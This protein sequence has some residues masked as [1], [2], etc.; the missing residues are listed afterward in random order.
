MPS[1]LSPVCFVCTFAD[2]QNAMPPDLASTGISERSSGPSISQDILWNVDLEAFSTRKQ[3]KLRMIEYPL[4][5]SSS[6]SVETLAQIRDSKRRRQS[7][8]GVHTARR[9]YTEV[10][11]E[12]ILQQT[13]LL[14]SSSKPSDT[15]SA[16]V[17]ARSEDSHPVKYRITTD[18]QSEPVESR[19]C[20][21]HNSRAPS[22]RRY[23]P[24]PRES[25]YH[26]R[27]SPT[28]RSESRDPTT[29]ERSHK[30]RHKH[31]H[32]HKHKRTEHEHRRKRR[33]S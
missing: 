16:M 20:E 4:N 13:E 29:H 12:I 6:P 10:L 25:G 23:S 31:K 2:S 17:T 24:H 7:Y 18:N 22:S 28:P 30:D 8:R 19:V 1:F 3:K 26:R 5:E 11:R 33:S 14:Q 27:R 9:S 21:S 15:S 32:W